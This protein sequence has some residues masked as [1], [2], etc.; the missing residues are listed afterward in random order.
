MKVAYLR[1]QLLSCE[2]A[3]RNAELVCTVTYTL[4]AG[5]Q[6][7]SSA[8]RASPSGCSAGRRLHRV[9]GRAVPLAVRGEQCRWR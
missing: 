5:C 4:Q 1:E 9:G 3:R 6:E 8:T 2:L 7:V